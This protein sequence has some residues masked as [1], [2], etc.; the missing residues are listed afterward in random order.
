MGA[1]Q[2]LLL[3]YDEGS[4]PL[5]E[6]G[7]EQTWALCQDADD[8]FADPPPPARETCELLRCAPEG[9][10]AA[11]LARARADGSAPLGRLTLETLDKSGTG[12]GTEGHWWLEDVRVVGDRLCARDLSLRDVTV[13]GLPS[14]DNPYNHP[15]RPPLSPG[16]RLLGPDGEPW[17]HCRDLAR[18]QEDRTEPLDP[19]VRLL[20]CSPRGALRVALDGG[21]EDLGHAKMLRI[22]SSGRPL[23]LV[24]EGELRAWIPSARGPGLVDLTLEPWTE[25][26]PLA[27][28]AVWDLW[29][30][31]RPSEPGRWA[32]CD[33]EGRRFWLGTALANHPH[34]A[35]DRPPGTTYH[36]DGRHVTDPQGFFCALGEAVN[37]PGGYFGWGVDALTDCLRGRWGAA[38]P[39]TLVWHEATVA[40]ACLGLTPHTGPHPPTFGELLA[41]LAERH[42]DVRLA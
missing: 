4:K 28:R 7:Y 13:E 18:P 35:P 11:A 9:G 33:T 15:H 20:G 36:L 29:G 8:L 25:R 22:D 16:Y 32:D 26:P 23:Q 37:G 21:D 3:S 31:G 10:L 30:E 41:L 17:G 19:P 39:F 14:D 6:H 5:G 40:R 1:P 38:A 27:A 24:V 2:Y 12:T 34:G 42:V